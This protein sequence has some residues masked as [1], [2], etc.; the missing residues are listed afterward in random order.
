MSELQA[1]ADSV[2]GRAGAGEQIEA[3]V[4]RGGETEVLLQCPT[5]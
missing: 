5:R 4:A 2:V 3:Y 1:V